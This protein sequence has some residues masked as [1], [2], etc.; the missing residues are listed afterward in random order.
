VND[1]LNFSF[2]AINNGILD[3]YQLK[4]L[5][6]ILEGPLELLDVSKSEN[7]QLHLNFTE[8]FDFDNSAM[9]LDYDYIIGCLGFKYDFDVF[10]Q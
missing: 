6:G 8:E 3:T 5:D 10:N 2:S 4:S 7:N 1:K 9:R